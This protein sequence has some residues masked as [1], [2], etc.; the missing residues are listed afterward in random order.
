[1]SPL[2][3]LLLSALA[4]ATLGCSSTPASTDA[5]GDGGGAADAGGGD[6]G[7]T[8]AICLRQHDETLGGATI[9]VCDEAFPSAPF[10]HLPADSSSGGVDTVYG[11]IGTDASGFGLIGRG[12]AFTSATVPSWADAEAQFGNLRYAYLLYRASVRAGVVESVTPVV[13]IDDRVFTRL[14]AGM[15]LEGGGSPRS[16]DPS[17][18]E[19]SFAVGDTSVRMRVR[20]DDAPADTET[21]QL[22]GFPRFALVGHVVNFS[23][24]FTAADGTCLP[25][26][27]SL[28]AA[29]PYFGLDGQMILLRYPGMH[30]AFDDVFTL[31]FDASGN[32]NMGEGL[33]VGPSDLIQATAPTL[34]DGSNGPHGTPTSGPSAT[35]TTVDPAMGGASCTP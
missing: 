9:T 13:R 18:G 27:T 15:V 30:A 12:V 32:V 6:A 2:R 28:G 31:A 11:G 23:S 7:P 21:D 1:M 26:L 3:S 22:V 24:A 8:D 5:G 34:T 29:N 33:Y 4:L 16:V 19:A 35:L 10:V 14:I 17:T 25:A 20:F